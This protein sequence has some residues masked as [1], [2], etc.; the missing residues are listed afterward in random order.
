MMSVQWGAAASWGKCRG[1]WLRHYFGGQTAIRPQ[2]ERRT[3]PCV[4]TPFVHTYQ[5]SENLLVQ[6][7]PTVSPLQDTSGS[8]LDQRPTFLLPCMLPLFFPPE[9]GLGLT[10]SGGPS[11]DQRR[12]ARPGFVDI[13]TNA[14]LTRLKMEFD[15]LVKER[16]RARR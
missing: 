6:I 12:W 5:R 9:S 14:R 8:P 2:L 4:T 10:T 13:S 1:S 7:L 11:A 16:A 3:W 15:A